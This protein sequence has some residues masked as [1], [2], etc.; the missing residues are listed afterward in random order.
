MRRRL[1]NG[2]PLLLLFTL[3]QW[4]RIAAAGAL[5]PGCVAVKLTDSKPVPKVR[6]RIDVTLTNQCGKDVTS[7]SIRFR[8]ANGDPPSGTQSTRI[9]WLEAL[10]LPADQRT[11]DILHAG[12]SDTMEGLYYPQE[13]LTASSLSASVTCVL[14]VDR[15]AAGDNKA[16]RD[17]LDTRRR[18]GAREFG[19]RQQMLANIS[20]FDAATVYFRDTHPAPGSLEDKYTVIFS[21]AFRGMSRAEWS[22]YIGQQIAMT[23]QL[24]ALF[25]EHSQLS[26]ENH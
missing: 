23:S 8:T 1:H 20:D 4:P 15:T 6:P 22:N 14:F 7:A 10:V 9:E 17:A 16:I 12:Q 19:L 26:A 21:Q 25:E 5:E 2:F 13:G 18:A 11:Y 24:I 3:G